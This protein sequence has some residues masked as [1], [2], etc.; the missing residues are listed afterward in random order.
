MNL[1]REHLGKADPAFTDP[2]SEECVW[3][4]R[5]HADRNWEDYVNTK[6]G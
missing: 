3:I 4:I 1:F 5:E 6:E 2:S